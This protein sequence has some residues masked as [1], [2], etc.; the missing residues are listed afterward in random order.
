MLQPW[1]D[2]VD[3]TRFSIHVK[4]DDLDRLLEIVDAVPAA[5]VTRMQAELACVWRFFSWSSL[6]GSLADEDGSSDAF[7][8]LMYT[9]RERKQFG[10]QRRKLSG[11]E[12]VPDG[13]APPQPLCRAG[14]CPNGLVPEWPHGGAAALAAATGRERKAGLEG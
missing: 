11:C 7:E 6:W 4:D 12:P 10:Q 8:L 2:Q 5:N 1:E 9:L 14:T 3:W 13:L